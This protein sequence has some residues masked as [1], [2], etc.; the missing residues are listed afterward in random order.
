MN[1]FYESLLIKD[2]VRDHMARPQ[3]KLKQSLIK[4]K[5]EMNKDKDNKSIFVQNM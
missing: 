2:K 3:T 1:N 4:H 5:K